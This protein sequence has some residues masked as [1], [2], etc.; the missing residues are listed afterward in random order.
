MDN[1]AIARS[2]DTSDR[3][4]AVLVANGE[5][6]RNTPAWRD[7]LDESPIVRLCVKLNGYEA[8]RCCTR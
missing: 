5:D 6:E 3:R 4:I 7:A 1:D 8:S 2:I